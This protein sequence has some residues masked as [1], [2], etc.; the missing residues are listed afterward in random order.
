MNVDMRTL[1]RILASL[2]IVLA[3]NGHAAS[4]APVDYVNPYMGNISHLLKPTYPT[5]HLPYG[6]LRFYPNR[7]SHVEGKVNGLPLIVVNHRENS[8]FTLSATQEADGRLH[9]VM[10]TDWDNEQITPYY[11]RSDLDQQRV[12]AEFSPSHHSAIVRLQFIELQP[13]FVI[14]DAGHGD[15]KVTGR[16]VV[17]HQDTWGGVKVFLYA[18]FDQSPQA[19]GVLRDNHLDAM[20]THSHG[21]HASVVMRYAGRST[22]VMRYAVSLISVDQ[23]RANFQAEVAGKSLDQVKELGRK[24]WN[25]ELG[26]IEVDGG[27]AGDRVVFYTSLYRCLERPVCI[28]EQGRYFCPA[29]HQVHSDEGHPFYT[30]DWLWDT[31]R[32]THPLRVLLDPDRETDIILSL[33]RTAEH[34]PR[35]WFPTFPAVTGDSRRMNCN[36]GVAVVADAWAK[37]LRG[38]DLAAAYDYCRRGIEE[39]TLAPWSSHEA[40][41]LD[42]FYRDHGYI[43]AL[44]PGEQETVP[45]VN[46]WEKRQAVAV[47][48]GTSYDQWCL[49]QIATALGR[50]DEARHYL[51]CSYN[52]RNLFNT[53]TSFFHPK[54]KDGQWIEPFDYKLAG[55]IGA[56]DYYDENNGWTYRWDV[57]HNPA[58]LIALMGGREAFVRN[59][60][61]TFDEAL[62]TERYNFYHQLPDQT[63]NVGQFTMGNEPSMHIPYLYNYAGQP[64]KT[65]KRVRDLVHQW[66]RNDLMGVPGD[67]DGGGLS[68]FVV[69]SMMGFYPVTPGIAAYNLGSPFFTATRIH[70]PGG[71]VLCIKAPKASEQAKYIV[72]ATVNGKRCDRPW[73]AHDDVA[74]G[75]TIV[76]DMSVRHTLWGSGAAAVPPSSQPCPQP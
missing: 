73:F 20:F 62:G 37:G 34:D 9:R 59:L 75:G 38:F 56:R 11:Y 40:T 31:Y 57:Q 43:P 69:F 65:Q 4:G 6:M 23:A 72:G 8:C 47:T 32:A 60:D 48:L 26:K 74:H 10:R 1:S 5:V 46:G 36:H 63:G 35:H 12:V 58:D 3:L 76:L 21:D 68:G 18:E 16:Q 25:D 17:G 13:G 61:Q 15:L 54:D 45:G 19:A 64:W 50:T 66:F 42:T 67:E 70:L 44:H 33:M 29:D 71:K 24:A 7:G 28:S 27:T 2:L 30:D 22:V 51:R 55:G 52:Y 49:S 53:T 41:W 14:L 39:K